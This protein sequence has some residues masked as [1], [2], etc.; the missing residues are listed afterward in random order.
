[1]AMDKGLEALAFSC[2]PADEEASSTSEE[3]RYMKLSLGK[4]VLMDDLPL[5]EEDGPEDIAS[6]EEVGVNIKFTFLGVGLDV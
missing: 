5:D 1:M 3:L 6:E 2:V 4:R